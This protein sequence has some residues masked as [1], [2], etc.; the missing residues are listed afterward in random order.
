MFSKHF[1]GGQIAPIP[2]E[3][4][5]TLLQGTFSYPFPIKIL[6]I[7]TPFVERASDEFF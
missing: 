3:K 6:K 1:L 5:E 7:K 4:S 2:S